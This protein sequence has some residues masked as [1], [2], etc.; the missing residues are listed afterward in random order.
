MSSFPAM[1]VSRS[2][3]SDAA[4]RDDRRLWTIPG[5]GWLLFIRV[6]M[7]EQ[8]ALVLVGAPAGSGG[9]R[10]LPSPGWRLRALLCAARQPC[11]TS[12]LL[13]PR[14]NGQQGVPVTVKH[15]TSSVFLFNSLDDGWRL[16]MIEHPRL[17]RLMIPG[18]H[19]EFDESQ[20]EAALREVTEETGIAQVQLVEPPGP[21]LPAAFP[22]KRVAPPWWIT[23]Q[24]VPADN[25]LA[26]PHVH[27]DHQYV[28][29]TDCAQPDAPGVHPF[30]WYRPEQLP[31]LNMWEDT[32]LLARVLFSC[33]EDLADGRL[34]G[35]S[36]LRQ[37]AA[38]AR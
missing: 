19:V 37:L 16:G 5:A 4:L 31:V 17:G 36:A 33:I 14:P 8:G 9:S 6:P 2:T 24:Q 1:C 20:A 12:T 30:S 28:A 23:E 15:L 11:V 29:V 18:G 25:H 26:E 21:A 22:H 3:C 35:A 7:V 32:R 13:G 38:A 10:S 34:A 27:V